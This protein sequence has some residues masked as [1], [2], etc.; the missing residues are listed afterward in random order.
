MD[1]PLRK[2]QRLHSPTDLVAD[3]PLA[4]PLQGLTCS[5]CDEIPSNH[6]FTLITNKCNHPRNICPDCVK[7]WISSKLDDV[8]AE[9]IS[10]PGSVCSEVIQYENMGIRAVGSANLVRF[11][12]L[13]TKALLSHDPNY[14]HCIG[15]DCISGQIHEEGA[16]APIL[17][18][19]DCGFKACFIHTRAWHSDETCKAFDKRL[20]SEIAKDAKLKREA[21][22]LKAQEEKSDRWV[23]KNAKRCPG[24]K[25]PI[26]KSDGCDHMQCSKCSHEFCYICLADYKAIRRRGNSAHKKGCVFAF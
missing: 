10:C 19:H 26:Q 6:Y 8:D 5:I 2:R 16:D 18:C 14:R 15:P 11:G 22:K 12:T 17:T 25:R 9:N 3:S 4:V 21:K 20:K 24:C 7:G 13:T 1:E 23:E